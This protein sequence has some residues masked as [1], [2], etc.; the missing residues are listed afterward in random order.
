MS[1]RDQTPLSFRE[2][3]NL[4]VSVDLRTASRAF[5]ICLATAYRQVRLGTFPCETIRVGRRHRVRTVDLMRALGIEERPIY[6]DDL[7]D[8]VALTLFE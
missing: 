2:V 6:A 3:M 5:G 1:D 4:P 7:A 8:G